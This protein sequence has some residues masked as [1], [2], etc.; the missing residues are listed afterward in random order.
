MIQLLRD[1]LVLLD[2]PFIRP[3]DNAPS[4]PLCLVLSDLFYFF[5]DRSVTSP[6]P[7]AMKIQFY[8]SQISSIP[9]SRL[10]GLRLEVELQIQKIVAIGQEEHPSVRRGNMNFVKISRSSECSVPH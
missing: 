2:T 5:R 7:T 8:A 6:D 4:T 1:I 9:A 10:N 3:Q